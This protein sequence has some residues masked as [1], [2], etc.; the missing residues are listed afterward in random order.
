[1]NRRGTERVS[2]TVAYLDP[3]RQRPNLTVRGDAHVRRILLDGSRAVGVELA[4]GGRV[5][6]E[7]VVLSSGVV[8]NPLLLWRSGVGPA[9]GITALGVRPVHELPEVGR[10]LTDHLVVS[11]R[12]AVRPEMVPDGGPTLQTIARATA[13]G[14]ERTHDIQ[15]T[16]VARRNPD[17]SREI[18]I[19]VALQLPTGAG[20]IVPTGPDVGDPAL[21]T[22]PFAGDP[23]N[24]RRL[25]EGW[26]LAARVVAAS[27]L[28]LDP[29][30]SERAAETTDAALD[31]MIA[32]SHY[33]FYHGVGTCRIGPDART[34]VVDAGLR[35]HG[36]DGLRVV[37][38]SVVPSVPR[39]NTHLLATALGEWGAE[40]VAEGARPVM[41]GTN[42]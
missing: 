16:P 3:A 24:L 17:G 38:A 14:S 8:Q 42:R 1:M 28:A 40:L 33:A 39:A 26:R 22:W 2:N 32:A 10:N 30:A 34:G 6:A 25:R 12:A 37:D 23:D 41:S 36:L 21:I 4:D 9:A 35:V 15:L 5:Y 7:Q 13:P 20:H 11:Y 29:G 27:G 18:E 31:E 19:S